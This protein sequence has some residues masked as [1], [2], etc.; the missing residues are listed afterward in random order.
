MTQPTL[1]AGAATPAGR[2]VL[3]WRPD[4]DA[5]RVEEGLDQAARFLQTPAAAVAA[6]IDRGELL[7]GW[8]VDWAASAT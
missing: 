2:R 1:P 3:L 4:S 6:A 7:G 8:F 5:S